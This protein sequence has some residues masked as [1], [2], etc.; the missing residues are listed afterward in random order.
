[1]PIT[2]W[3]G[4][5]KMHICRYKHGPHP[6]HEAEDTDL[7]AHQL[8]E[9]LSEVNEKFPKIN[10][11]FDIPYLAGYSNDGKTI[12]IDRHL[13]KYLHTQSLKIDVDQFLVLHEA[14]EKSLIDCLGLKYQHAHQIALRAERDAVK[15]AGIKWRNYDKFMRRYIKQD[16]HEKLTKVPQDLDLTPY[17]DE[18]DD[19]LLNEMSKKLG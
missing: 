12:Y 8:L 6:A 3:D 5:H 17:R 19:D 15:I 4:D 11:D 10:R 7:S 13:P 14:I 16:G 2:K 18:H 9:T 1:M